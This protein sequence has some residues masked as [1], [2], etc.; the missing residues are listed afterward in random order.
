MFK[1]LCIVQVL[2]DVDTHKG[3]TIWPGKTLT[4]QLMN[5][6]RPVY[7]YNLIM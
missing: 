3:N 1:S 2:I 4:D 6:F 5:L 7:I